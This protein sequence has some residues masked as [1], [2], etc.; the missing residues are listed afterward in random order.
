MRLGVQ[1]S[2]GGWSLQGRMLK[3]RGYQEKAVEIYRGTLLSL[4]DFCLVL[5]CAK[6][7]QGQEQDSPWNSHKDRNSL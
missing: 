7:I 3:R 4:V 6:T 1:G 5:V 2:Q